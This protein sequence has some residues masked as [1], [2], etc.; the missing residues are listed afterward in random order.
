M[1]RMNKAL[2]IINEFINVYVYKLLK[3]LKKK[4]HYAK[5][6]VGIGLPS[7]TGRK[8]DRR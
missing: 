8:S 2:N 1:E 7:I 4:I 3:H 6:N 5:T